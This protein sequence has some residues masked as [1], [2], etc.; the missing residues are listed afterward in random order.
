MRK[1]SKTTL[2]CLILLCSSLNALAQAITGVVN[3]EQGRALEYVNVVHL[4]TAKHFVAGA[5]TGADGTFSIPLS[6]ASAEGYIVA[7]YVGMKTDTIRIGSTPPLIFV[8]F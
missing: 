7:S 1:I 8:S 5:I 3:D 4:N 6:D 2:I